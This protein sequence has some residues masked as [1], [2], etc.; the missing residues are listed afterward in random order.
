M[1]ILTAAF[2]NVL[3]ANLQAGYKNH[4]A[5]EV[6]N[7]GDLKAS[8]P[9]TVDLYA[10]PTGSSND[11]VCLFLGSV[12]RNMNLKPGHESSVNIRFAEPG[13]LADGQYYL[14]A[15]I[16][17]S[18][19]I[20]NANAASDIVVAPARVTAQQPAADLVAK[21]VQ[22]PKQTLVVEGNIVTTAPVS[23]TLVN[24]GN[25]AAVGPVSISFYLSTDPTGN[26][27]QILAGTLPNASIYLK[28]G[29]FQGLSRA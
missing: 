18:E 19:S 5:I 2:A 15:T 28:P 22:A 4:V 10:S 9:V 8:G 23:V 14:V 25:A 29:G 7:Q 17:G 3:P 1:R 13:D 11:E 26:G 6:S 12:T 20:I 24:K 21:T 16:G 27:T